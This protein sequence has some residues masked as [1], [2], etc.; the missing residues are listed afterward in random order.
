[1]NSWAAVSVPPIDAG[2]KFPALSLWD[3][4]RGGA[5]PLPEKS[6]YRLYVCGI[7]P[8]DA[9]HL[10]H[11]ATYLTLPIAIYEPADQKFDLSRTLPISMIHF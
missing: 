2:F 9:T 3:T 6:L 7:T 4:A 5:F 10:G 11:A 8:Y 1:M